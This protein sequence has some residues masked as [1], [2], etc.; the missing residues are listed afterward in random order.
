MQNRISV[1][2]SLSHMM[3]VWENMKLVVQRCEVTLPAVLKCTAASSIVV[4][5]WSSIMLYMLVQT[6]KSTTPESVRALN[7][8]LAC[9]LTVGQ[10]DTS[11]MV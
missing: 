4:L 2:G 3:K 8:S 9:T 5:Y 10:S 11:P 7:L 6:S 1:S